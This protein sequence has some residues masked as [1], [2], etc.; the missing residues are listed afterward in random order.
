[1]LQKL[2]KSDLLPGH[3]LQSCFWSDFKIGILEGITA[4]LY[5]CKDAVALSLGHLGLKGHS[6]AKMPGEALKNVLFITS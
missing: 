3:K 1:M 5:I 4:A 6:L 2:H